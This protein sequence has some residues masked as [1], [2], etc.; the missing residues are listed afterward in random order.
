VLRLGLLKLR[1]SPLYLPTQRV[2]RV[3]VRL[4]GTLGTA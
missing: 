1:K 4:A 2:E 3:L